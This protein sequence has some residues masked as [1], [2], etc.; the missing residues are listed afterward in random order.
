M[1]A[2]AER[3]PATIVTQLQRAV[4][5]RFGTKPAT[6][7]PAFTGIG[8]ADARGR[9]I[10]NFRIGKGTHDLAQ[11]I[12]FRHMIRIELGDE[13]ITLVTVVIVEISEIALLAACAPRPGLAM[14]FRNALPGGN[15]NA[16]RTAPFQRLRIRS[17][18]GKPDVELQALL[19]Q[20]RQQRLLH[21][22]E[23]FRR[24]LGDNHRHP[25][26]RQ[27][28]TPVDNPGVEKDED[29]IGRQ[30]RDPR[31]RRRDD[32]VIGPV[33]DAIAIEPPDPEVG[34]RHQP[35]ADAEKIGHAVPAGENRQHPQVAGGG[36]HTGR[37]NGRGG[38]GC[39]DRT[40]SPKPGPAVRMMVS[41]SERF[42]VKPSVSSA[43]LISANRAG[44]SP[45]RLA[46]K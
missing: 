7:R 40:S 42:G 21:H 30:K 6:R 10:S 27:R 34:E 18:I 23:R 35:A 39:H 36:V 13:I 12:R 45:A 43:R 25:A 41:I 2:D 17:L 14:I 9:H 4:Q 28:G 15:E 32:G 33:D 29:E 5:A 16:V 20:H 1:R 31:K 24:R 3:R 8:V 19:L 38:A 11:I 44:G 26:P 46:P 22:R 37:R